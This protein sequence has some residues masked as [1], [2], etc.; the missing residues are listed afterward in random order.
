[1]QASHGSWSPWL[2]EIAFATTRSGNSE[3]FKMGSDGNGPT[4]LSNHTAWDG[5]PH[6]H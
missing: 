6:W 4:N 3:I 5:E 1:M 2:D